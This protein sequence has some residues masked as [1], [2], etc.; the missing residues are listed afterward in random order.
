MKARSRAAAL[1]GALALASGAVTS[2]ARAAPVTVEITSYDVDL[3][4]ATAFAGAGGLEVS[5]AGRMSVARLSARPWRERWDLSAMRASATKAGGVAAGAYR[6]VDAPVFVER[7]AAGAP[8]RLGFSPARPMRAHASSS[9]TSWPSSPCRGRPRGAL[10]RAGARRHGRV[11]R[12]VDPWRVGAGAS[13]GQARLRAA[14][15]AARHHGDGFGAPFLARARMAA[16]T[17]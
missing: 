12:G 3:R 14:G 11:R 10:A 1:L 9:S 16:S 2:G 13:H 15:G 6:G 4:Y 7:D 5:F 17:P 8:T